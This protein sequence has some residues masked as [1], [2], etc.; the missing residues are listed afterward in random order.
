MVPGVSGSLVVLWLVWFAGGL[1]WSGV[2]G[3]F[4]LTGGLVG[5]LVWFSLL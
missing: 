5:V 2:L 4:G 3:S 1:V